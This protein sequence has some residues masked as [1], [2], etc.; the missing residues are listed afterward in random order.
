[1]KPILEILVGV[2]T[3]VFGYFALTFIT[4]ELLQESGCESATRSRPGS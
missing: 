1:M 2:P 4:P 3:V